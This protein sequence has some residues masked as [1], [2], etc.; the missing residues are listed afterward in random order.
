[1]KPSASACTFS[2]STS[3]PLAPPHC[4]VELP[5]S[6]ITGRPLNFLRGFDICDLPALG[7]SC[8]R[9]SGKEPMRKFT[10]SFALALP[11]CEY[12]TNREA[13]PQPSQVLVVVGES[14]LLIPAP[15]R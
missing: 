7:R 10:V 14:Q 1:D 15:A 2:V 6:S 5:R 4:H 8:L 11:R 3:P 12:R 9:S 13:R